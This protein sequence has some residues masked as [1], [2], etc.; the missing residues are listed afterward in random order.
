MSLRGLRATLVIAGN[1]FSGTNRIGI[2]CSS[3]LDALFACM[4]QLARTDVEWILE[5]RSPGTSFPSLKQHELKRFGE[6][7]TQRYVLEAF[8]RVSKGES[9]SV[10]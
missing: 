4:Y 10:V 2:A 5:S 9:P 7:R 8:D 1:R 3:E 6:Y